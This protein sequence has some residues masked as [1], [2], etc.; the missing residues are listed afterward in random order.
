MFGKNKQ[1]RSSPSLPD[2]L[3]N[4]SFGAIH[5]KIRV[6]P[7]RP[8]TIGTQSTSNS[9]GSGQT[10][11]NPS[12]NPLLIILLVGLL[13][14]GMICFGVGAYAI[15]WGMTRTLDNVILTHGGDSGTVREMRGDGEYAQRIVKSAAND[16][17]KGGTVFLVIAVVSFAGAYVVF[18]RFV[19][20]KQ[21]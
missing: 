18:I 10:R 9:G 5:A 20:R 11:D 12:S 2:L 7:T 15:L 1:L 16:A 4:V 3:S 19:R 21:E 8:N 17:Y 13:V 14:V 6:V